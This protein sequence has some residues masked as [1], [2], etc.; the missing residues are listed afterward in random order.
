[1]TSWTHWKYDIKQKIRLCQPTRIYLEKNPAK[2][3]PD[4]IWN[5]GA[6]GFLMSAP[7]RR[8]TARY[9]NIWDQFLIQEYWQLMITNEAE[10]MT[11]LWFSEYRMRDNWCDTESSNTDTSSLCTHDTLSV[12]PILYAKILISYRSKKTDIDPTLQSIFRSIS[13]YLLN[14]VKHQTYHINNLQLYLRCYCLLILL[15][16]CLHLHNL[17][18]TV[19]HRVG[20]GWPKKNVWLLLQ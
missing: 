16:K 11:T 13:T 10:E 12:P 8:T 14:K 3:H 4:P 18:L 9:V 2:F 5:G 1:M 17:Q 19:G 7:R 6:L 15:N 20:P